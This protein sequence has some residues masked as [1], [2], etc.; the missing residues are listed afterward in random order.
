MSSEKLK[1]DSYIWRDSDYLPP[2]LS[3]FT[4]H[5]VTGLSMNNPKIDIGSTPWITMDQ[6]QSR[7]EED[8]GYGKDEQPTKKDTHERAPEHYS[9]YPT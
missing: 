4:S 8:Y 1:T 9:K 2:T 5:L 3:R 7:T 6:R